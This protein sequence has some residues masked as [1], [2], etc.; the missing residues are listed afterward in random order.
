[1]VRI[2]K[3]SFNIE[4]IANS[5]QCFRWQRITQNKY[6]FVANGQYTEIMTDKNDILLSCSPS[7]F[8]GFLKDYFD[9]STDYFSIKSNADKE[10]AYLQNAIQNFGDITILHQNLWEVIVSFIISQRKSIPAIQSCIEKICEKFGKEIAALSFEGK[11]ITAHDFPTAEALYDA[12]IME[13]QECGVGYRDKYI[14]AAAEWYL[15]TPKEMITKESVKEIFGVGNKV[16]SC[17]GLFGLHDLSCCPIDVWMQRIIDIRYDGNMPDWMNSKYA[18]IYQQY[19]FM[20]ERS[21]H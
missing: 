19:V 7:Y 6:A 5:G 14:K 1:M 10:D 15:S 2:D 16:A 17:I 4:H 8:E 21:F 3:S 20:Y 11:N 12:P 9:L 18:G 13:I